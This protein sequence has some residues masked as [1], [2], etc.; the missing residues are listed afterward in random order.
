MIEGKDIIVHGLQSLDSPIGSNCINLAYEFSKHNRILYVNYPMDRLTLLR[1][2]KDSLVI[3]RKQILS[4]KSPELEK[5]QDNMWNLNPKTTLESISKIKSKI[6]FSFFNKINNKRYAKRI[7][8]AVDELG[9]KDYIIFNDSD[10]YRALYFKEYLKPKVSV[11][12]TR[13]NMRATEFFSKHGACFEDQLMAKSDLVVA[14]S[15]YLQQIAKNA[16]PNSFYVG[17]G[18]DVSVFDKDLIKGLPED[19]KNINSPIIGYI[20]ALK[21]SRLDIETLEHIAK[22][23]P[24]W[25]I[26]LVGP[27]DDQFKQSKL[28]QL[29]NVLFLGSK[30]MTLL[31]DYLK[32]F[33]VALNPQALNPLTI[34][35]YPRKIDEYL[36][37]GKPVVA[38]QTETMQVFKEFVYLAKNKEE[39]ILHIEKALSE[40]NE[41]LEMRRIKFARKHTWENNVK[42]IYKA[43]ASVAL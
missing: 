35:N 13:D 29:G 20:G 23:K 5:V 3:K 34:G 33:D 27:E 19:M 40:N 2:R 14:N 12:Y 37:M 31:P 6:L 17:Q 8:K 16:N 38:T 26:V 21:S 1:G 4:G 42:A 43:I 25:K 36:A 28:H 30:P 10:F 15:V 41:D 7:Q 9:F 18:C 32:A 39:Y 11:Y 22:S 24:A